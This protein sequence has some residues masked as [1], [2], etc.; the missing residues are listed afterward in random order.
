MIILGIETSCDDTSAAIFDGSRL[1]SNVISTQLIHRNFGGVVPELASR[2]HIQ[3]LMPVIKQALDLA[4]ISKTDLQGI[5]VTYGPGLAGSLLAGLSAAK[6]MAL[7]LGIP[8]IGVNHL[9]GH[10]WGNMLE[11]PD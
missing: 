1:L 5:A 3:L 4:K 6:G 7:G 9:E 8:L 2:S 11:H 10:I